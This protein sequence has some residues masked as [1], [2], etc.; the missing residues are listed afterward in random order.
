MEI[1]K[2]LAGRVFIFILKDY[3]FDHLKLCYLLSIRNA[4]LILVVS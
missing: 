2:N 3:L 1:I 4:N